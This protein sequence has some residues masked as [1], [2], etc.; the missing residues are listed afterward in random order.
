MRPIIL[1]AAMLF[2]ISAHADYSTDPKKV[3]E[4]IVAGD[5][6]AQAADSRD[7]GLPPA[8]ALKTAVSSTGV[9]PARA[10]K[11]INLV[12]FDPHFIGASGEALSQQMTRACLY[13]GSKYKPLQ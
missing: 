1:F 4:C 6:F 3:H 5:V 8:A 13:T 2:S 9:D 11:I 10:K 7:A 12:Y